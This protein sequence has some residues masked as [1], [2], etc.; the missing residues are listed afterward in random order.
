MD[1]RFSSY[2]FDPWAFLFLR[3]S[4]IQTT[5][6]GP[7]ILNF[8][9]KGLD[10]GCILRISELFSLGDLDHDGN[11]QTLSCRCVHVN[12]VMVIWFGTL[13]TIPPNRTGTTGNP[14]IR[15]RSRSE[16]VGGTLWAEDEERDARGALGLGHV[17]AL[18]GR[19]RGRF[20]RQEW[21]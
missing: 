15:Q 10:S 14:E 20:S 17:S 12:L 9:Q 5:S 11:I 16:G 13:Y 3:I 1:L 8:Q 7:E 4:W 18:Q 2:N 6:W 21:Q 19:P